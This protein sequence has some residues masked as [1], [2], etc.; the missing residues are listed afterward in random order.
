MFAVAIESISCGI[1]EGV[2]LTWHGI[3]DQTYVVYFTDSLTTAWNA[4]STLA[5]TGGLVEW[6]DDGTATGT[7]PMAS[8]VLNRFYRLSGQP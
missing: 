5:G 1:A 4:A 7:S 6:L 2:R 8:G 3:A